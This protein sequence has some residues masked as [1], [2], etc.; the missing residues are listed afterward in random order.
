MNKII[1]IVL[2]I[3]ACV[4]A[5]SC[6]ICVTS[7]IGNTQGSTAPSVNSIVGRWEFENVDYVMTFNADHTG[8]MC[9]SD[10][11]NSGSDYRWSYDAEADVYA[12]YM[13]GKAYV[14][15][16]KLNDDGNWVYNGETAVKK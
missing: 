4:C 1:A 8:R 6:V 9:S 11:E 12:I 16:G 10:D 5:V 7:V 14:Y 13:E 15:Y 3:L 2:A